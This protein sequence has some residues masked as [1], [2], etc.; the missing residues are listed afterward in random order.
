MS[1]TYVTRK[2]YDQ[3]IN[4]AAALARALRYPITEDMV[5][6]SAGIVYGDSQYDAFEN[7]LWS[8][9]PYEVMVIFEALNEPAVDGLPAAAGEFSE[10]SGL[11]D[12]LMIMHPGKFCPPHF[13]MRK[14]ESY[15]VLMGEMELFYSPVEVDGFGDTLAFE[16]MPKGDSWPDGVAIPAGRGETYE[17]L[18]SFQ[19]LLPGSKKFVMHRKHLHAFRCAA[20]SK[21]PLV[22]RE[23]ST[24]SHEPTE[25]VKDKSVPLP[26]WKGLHDNTFLA[27]EANSGRL[28]TKIV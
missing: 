1:R 13:H 19:R 21:V 20:N 17:R 2:E 28:V 8:G 3:W 7:G 11:C 24:Y 12:K 16:S 4:E 15:E 10:Y 23:I 22:V 5:N 18:T 9:E 27:E 25:A 14:T 6:D 26:S